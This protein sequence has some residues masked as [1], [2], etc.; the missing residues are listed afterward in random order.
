METVIQDKG[1]KLGIIKEQMLIADGYDLDECNDEVA[2]MFGV[3]NRQ[4]AER[5]QL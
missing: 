4:G 5:G 2:E 3:N 1:R